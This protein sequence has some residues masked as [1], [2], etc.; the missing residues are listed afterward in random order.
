VSPVNQAPTDEPMAYLSSQLL[1]PRTAAMSEKP[2]QKGLFRNIAKMTLIIV[3]NPTFIISL[4]TCLVVLLIDGPIAA[5]ICVVP[6]AILGGHEEMKKNKAR[7]RTEQV[8]AERRKRQFE[9]AKNRKTADHRIE[10][11][12][13]G[14]DNTD[15]AREAPDAT[16]PAPVGVPAQHEDEE[17]ESWYDIENDI[18]I[19]IDIEYDNTQHSDPAIDSDNPNNNKGPTTPST[20]SRSSE[21]D[22]QIDPRN[23]PPSEPAESNQNPTQRSTS[24]PSKTP[25]PFPF[26]STTGESSKPPK[27]LNSHNRSDRSHRSPH[28]NHP[29]HTDP[30][31]IT[32][33]F[34]RPRLSHPHPTISSGEH[35]THSAHHNPSSKQEEE[36]ASFFDRNAEI[37]ATKEMVL[38]DLRVARENVLR[39]GIVL[40]EAERLLGGI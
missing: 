13:K 36:G 16:E 26:R 19:Q 9:N 12:S 17:S 2:T 30:Y 8:W 23:P 31:P 33:P 34:K 40:G 27:P 24:Q 10:N 35:K 22:N 21:S 29:N 37:R 15:T 39:T 5:L 20:L 32:P 1:R 3:Q 6:C 38:R 4:L 28:P 11:T 7:R 14:G 25:T 18:E